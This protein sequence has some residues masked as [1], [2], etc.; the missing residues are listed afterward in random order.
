[1]ACQLAY[2]YFFKVTLLRIY[3]ICHTRLSLVDGRFWLS[4]LHLF[5]QFTLSCQ[6]TLLHQAAPVVKQV[7]ATNQELKAILTRHLRSV[8]ALQP[9]SDPAFVQ[10]VCVCV[11]ACT[12]LHV[13][14]GLHVRL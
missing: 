11:C 5:F 4:R 7:R 14:V 3:A 10:L 6:C 9:Y 2:L 13:R 8:P 12:R 1:M